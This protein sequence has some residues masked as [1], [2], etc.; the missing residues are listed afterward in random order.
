ML[1]TGLLLQ[2]AGRR[3]DNILILQIVMITQTYSNLLQPWSRNQTSR[4]SNMLQH[5][6][7]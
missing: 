3:R 6:L 1:F 5:S 4:A 2:I 7:G